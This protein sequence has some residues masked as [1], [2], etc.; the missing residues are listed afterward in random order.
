MFDREQLFKVLVALRR[1]EIPFLLAQDAFTVIE[2]CIEQLDSIDES[3]HSFKYQME[4]SLRADPNDRRVD[5]CYRKCLELQPLAPSLKARL[6]PLADAAIKFW[7]CAPCD[8]SRRASDAAL[9][10]WRSYNDGAVIG[11][12]HLKLINDFRLLIDSVLLS[13]FPDLVERLRI[14]E[15]LERQVAAE[16]QANAFFPRFSNVLPLSA[17]ETFRKTNNSFIGASKYPMT[18]YACVDPPFSALLGYSAA[19]ILCFPTKSYMVND[20]ERSSLTECLMRY[21]GGKEKVLVAFYRTAKRD[22]VAVHWEVCTQPLGLAQYAVGFEITEELEKSQSRQV[23]NLQ[24]MLR[25]WL[26]SIRNASFEQQALVLLEE[27]RSLQSTLET[28]AHNAQISNIVD[29]LKMLIH[30]AKTSV[31]LIDQALDTKG[32]VQQMSVADFVSNLTKFPH[33]FAESEGIGTIYVKLDVYFN[34]R[35]AVVADLE[36]LFVKCDVIG[37]QALVDHVLSDAV[38]H[39]DPLQGI[40]MTLKILENDGIL[41]FKLKVSDFCTTGLSDVALATYVKALGPY[42]AVD[43]R[44]NT[45][46]E[47]VLPTVTPSAVDADALPRVPDL[48]LA[49]SDLQ[50]LP[51]VPR[52]ESVESDSNESP[53]TSPMLTDMVSGGVDSL[54][55]PDMSGAPRRPPTIPMPS[56]PPGLVPPAP[57]SAS[58]WA[59]SVGTRTSSQA[60][61]CTSSGVGHA[62]APPISGVG[63]IPHL[64]E[65]YEQLVQTSGDFKMTIRTTWT[66]TTYRIRFNANVITPMSS[67][68]NIDRSIS[69][70]KLIKGT[71]AIT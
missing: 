48:H 42:K 15:E 32:L 6:A 71:S 41:Y 49:D 2:S 60:G 38:R 63:G 17:I 67:Y 58:N 25:Q 8:C 65:L 51:P 9:Q 5:E 18:H 31:G 26:H 28:D 56:P 14:E 44:P 54:C 24:K 4:D 46:P 16:V 40:E 50:P 7:H 39:T 3:L 64:A 61:G 35:R 52:Q 27:I 34:E 59:P 21:Y 43:E 33:N 29:G 70:S 20:W 55:A 30:T 11:D 47:R 62:V 12:A 69:V 36:R 57:S 10:L 19:R 66:G 45:V 37:L 23:G 13:D 1:E 68:E 22:I 53:K